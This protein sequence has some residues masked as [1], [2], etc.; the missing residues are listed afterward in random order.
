MFDNHLSTNGLSS[1][2]GVGDAA[3][4]WCA[5]GH[6]TLDF[7]EC[8]LVLLDVVVEGAK[9]VLGVL[10]SHDDAALHLGLR[11]VGGHGDEVDEKLLTA[12]RD[13]GE[14]CIVACCLGL[15][16]IVLYFK[17]LGYDYSMGRIG[18]DVKASI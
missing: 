15:S 12:V 14:V 5:C 2:E 4:S 6:L 1:F 11:H 7:A 16:M 17:G 18:S 8:L 13:Y 10:G 9:E 3:A